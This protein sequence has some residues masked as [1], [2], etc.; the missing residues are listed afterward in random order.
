MTILLDSQDITGTQQISLKG[1]VSQTAL[2]HHFS[3][4]TVPRSHKTERATAGKDV[5]KENA[6]AHR[7]GDRVV[8]GFG[9][10]F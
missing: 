9:N 10:L 4:M 5:A 3:P 2:G 8:Q 1:P 6:H 7:Q